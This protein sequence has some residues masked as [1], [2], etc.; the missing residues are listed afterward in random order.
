[1]WSRD[2][3]IGFWQAIVLRLLFKMLSSD[4]IKVT[5]RDWE[6]KGSPAENSSPNA[7]NLIE[8]V[9]CFS[10]W[11]IRIQLEL[12]RRAIFIG[13]ISQNTKQIIKTALLIAQ[14][15]RVIFQNIKAVFKNRKAVLSGRYGYLVKKRAKAGKLPGYLIKSARRLEF[16]LS[17]SHRNSLIAAM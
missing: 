6:L 13:K 8:T 16:L 9:T 10:D 5:P 3:Q 14:N 1:M 15:R 4:T 7:F 17:Y 11:K 2:R 12:V